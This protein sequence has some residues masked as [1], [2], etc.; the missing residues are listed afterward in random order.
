MGGGIISTMC[1]GQSALEN[2]KL[3]RPKAG[4]ECPVAYDPELRTA[5]SGPAVAVEAACVLL[6]QLVR[7]E[8]NHDHEATSRESGTIARPSFLLA[9]GSSSSRSGDREHWDGGTFMSFDVIFRDGKFL[10]WYAAAPTE[11]GG[12]TKMTI[13]I[14]HGTSQ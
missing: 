1:A 11:H 12:E 9:C 2:A 6:K 8:G 7:D 5:T 4:P 13:Q 3:P 14:G 10:F